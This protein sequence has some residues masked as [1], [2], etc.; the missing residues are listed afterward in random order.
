LDRLW[1][2]GYHFDCLR[3]PDDMSYKLSLFFSLDMYRELLKPIHKRAIEWAHAKGIVAY[4]HSCGDV[5]PFI[6][7][8]VEMGLDGLNPLEVKAGVDPV[9]VKR[10]FGDRILL[11]GGFNALDWYDVD[12]M[13]DHVRRDLPVLMT[14][15]GYIFST[16]HST[17]S[18]A[19]L[20]DFR[21]IVAVVKEVGVY[22]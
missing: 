21:R 5:R 17:P 12:A 10:E 20:E 16:D 11:H 1:D 4:L 9:A 2:A 13:E 8:L 6:P 18:N 15:G 14:D 7:E 22:G 3:W 19:G